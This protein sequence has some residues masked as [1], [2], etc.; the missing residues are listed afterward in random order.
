MPDEQ[1]EIPWSERDWSTAEFCQAKGISKWFFEQLKAEG[2][3]PRLLM[4]GPKLFRIT[5]Q[6]R[7]EWEERM[8]REAE[9]KSFLMERKRRREH[10]RA[11]AAK[12]VAVRKSR[13]AAVQ[14]ASKPAG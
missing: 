9:L 2:R 3:A 8:R 6:A 10:L 11:A 13:R 7:A 14:V 5:P 4:Y 12:S 1:E